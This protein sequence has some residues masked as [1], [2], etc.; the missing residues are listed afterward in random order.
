MWKNEIVELKMSKIE[1]ENKNNV[2]LIRK[3]DVLGIICEILETP[4]DVDF[5]MDERWTKFE[6]RGK[7][8]FQSVGPFCKSEEFKNAS[9]NYNL[10]H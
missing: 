2:R 9:F 5:R 6:S 10:N 3:K 8:N 1:R 4:E 7:E